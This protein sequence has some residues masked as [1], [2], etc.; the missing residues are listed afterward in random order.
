MLACLILGHMEAVVA[1]R[2]VLTLPLV[3]SFIMVGWDL[4]QDPVWSTV[5]HAWIWLGGGD[6]FGVPVSNFIGW[7]VTSYVLYQ[8]FAL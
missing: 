1:G 7:F 5:L 4:S 8:S 6:Y 3:A 2:P